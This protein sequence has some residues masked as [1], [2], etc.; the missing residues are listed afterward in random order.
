[1]ATT[2]TCPHGRDDHVM[3][4]GTRVRE[5]LAKGELPPAEFTRPE[6][7]KILSEAAR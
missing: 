3:L 5:M 4:S 7:A 1:M 2:K 6:V